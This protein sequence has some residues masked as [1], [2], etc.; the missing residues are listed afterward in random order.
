MKQAS[1]RRRLRAMQSAYDWLKDNLCATLAA[2]QGG[3]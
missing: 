2:L 1:M 3:K